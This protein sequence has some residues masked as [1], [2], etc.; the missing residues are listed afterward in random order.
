M[1]QIACPGSDQKI[2]NLELNNY[3]TIQIENNHK[4]VDIKHDDNIQ[5][6]D[7]DYPLPEFADPF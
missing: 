3:S 5:K 6:T 2:D 4:Q 1:G 7:L